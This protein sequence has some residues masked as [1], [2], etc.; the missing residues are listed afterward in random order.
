MIK[1]VPCLRQKSRKTYPGWPHVP[2]KPLQGNT[3]PDR[4][5]LVN[6]H[7][8]R[9]LRDTRALEHFMYW[10][11]IRERERERERGGGGGGGGDGGVKGISKD[12]N[13]N[14]TEGLRKYYFDI[15]FLPTSASL[16]LAYLP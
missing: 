14:K 7:F 2:I 10:T 11:L 4:L 13:Q 8:F 1:S 12:G 9:S 15:H 5:L 6:R 3:P 16:N